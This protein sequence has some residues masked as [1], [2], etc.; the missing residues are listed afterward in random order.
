MASLWQML[1]GDAKMSAI[2]DDFVDLALADPRVNYTRSGRYFLNPEAIVRTKKAALSFLRGA[3]GGPSPYHGRSLR[4]IHRGMQITD[5]EFDAVA[6][7]FRAALQRN[8]VD[9]PV[10]LLA[11]AAVESIRDQIVEQKGS[12]S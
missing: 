9:P 10:V 4:E 12:F 5:A 8:A 3:T 7:D 2:V 6:E 1:G 11:L